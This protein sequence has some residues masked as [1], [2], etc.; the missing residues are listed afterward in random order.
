ME[1][2]VINNGGR[3][4]QNSVRQYQLNR[5]MGK[6]TFLK[7]LVAQLE[8]QD[9]L[10]PMDNTQ[11][12]SQ[13]AQFSALEGI[14]NL[15]T[16]FKA[17]SSG[18]GELKNYTASTLVGRLVKVE[19]G[20]FEFTGEP[21]KLAYLLEEDAS[22]VTVTIRDSLGKPI[23]KMNPQTTKRGEYEVIWDGK[24]QLGRT[25]SQGMYQI[26][27]T[28]ADETGN[29]TQAPT[30]IM[31]QIRGIKIEDNKVYVSVGGMT[32]P[33]DDVKEIY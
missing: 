15:G 16:E 1:I 26:E 22:T 18:I 17:V 30:Y 31:E 4:Q 14:N 2:G 28:A 27:V 13:L 5:D 10:S 32:I 20:G 7:L 3:E 29:T 8:H 23:K 11:F 9:P 33:L 25:L 12:L 21:V 19:G 6:E 24:D